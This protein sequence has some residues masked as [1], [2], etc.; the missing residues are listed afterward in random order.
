MWYIFSYVSAILQ[1]LSSQNTN[2]WMLILWFHLQSSTIDTRPRAGVCQM[3][4]NLNFGQTFWLTH[5]IVP[6][7][8][9]C[10]HS[11]FRK[12]YLPSLCCLSFIHRMYFPSLYLGKNKKQ[13]YGTGYHK[14]KLGNMQCILF[15]HCINLAIY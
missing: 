3:A 5:K 13:N 11:I 6:N 9:W 8:P 10:S 2:H 7:W 12:M 15:L 4:V 14:S 1:R